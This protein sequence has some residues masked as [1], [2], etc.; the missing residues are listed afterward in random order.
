M[1]SYAAEFLPQLAAQWNRLATGHQRVLLG[2]SGGADSTALLL[3]IA[4]LAER[5][6]LQ[7]GVA[8]LNHGLRGAESVADAR[9]AEALATHYSFPCY[10]E[11][12]DI[13]AV[14]DAA[15]TGIE[16]TARRQRY[17]F[18]E[19]IARQDGYTAI[20][21]GHHADDQV[22]TVLHRLVR[23]TGLKGLAGIPASRRLESGVV[24][25]RP[26]L[27]I[28]RAVIE[29]WLREQGQGWREDAS[30]TDPQFTRN[31]IRGELLPLLEQSFNPRVRE[32]VLRLSQQAEEAE[33][34]LQ[35]VTQTLLKTVLLYRSPQRVSLCGQALQSQAVD[36][37][38]R[39]L[40]EVWEQQRWSQQ[41]MGMDEW[42]QLARLSESAGTLQLPGQ[43]TARVERYIL[44]LTR[45]QA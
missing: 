40:R 11:E 37:R 32:A 4:A 24:I 44:T 34:V 28:S 29:D 21:L 41:E 10:L 20:V 25:L 1:T 27:T 31:R 42:D 18:L 14:A 35:T 16:E 38:R 15:G 17:E 19:R 43:I 5:F 30:N 22:E 36:L 33:S 6:G 23:G 12:C 39:C 13:R 8:H 3:G 7:P 2:V 26:L 45:E 9:Y